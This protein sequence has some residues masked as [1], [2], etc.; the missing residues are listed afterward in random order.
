MLEDP[1][2]LGKGTVSAEKWRVAS[3]ILLVVRLQN[4][5]NLLSSLEDTKK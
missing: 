3:G 5:S 1:L 4:I 2:N